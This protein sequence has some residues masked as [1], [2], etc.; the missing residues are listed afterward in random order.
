MHDRRQR[1][2][3]AELVRTWHA[4]VVRIQRITRRII[5]GCLPTW[6]KP[7]LEEGWMLHSLRCTHVCSVSVISRDSRY[8]ATLSKKAQV[9]EPRHGRV[10]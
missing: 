10:A 3:L 1:W 6:G 9:E 4:P 7:Q 2:L 5:L 8:G